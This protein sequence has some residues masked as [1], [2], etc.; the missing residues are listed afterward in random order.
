[1]DPLNLQ[2]CQFHGGAIDY[3]ILG[4]TI[5]NCLFERV[6]TTLYI[7]AYTSDYLEPLYLRNNLFWNGSLQFYFGTT[8]HIIQDNVFYQTA[9]AD[10]TSV[11]YTAEYNAYY[12]PTNQYMGITYNPIPYPNVTNNTDVFLTNDPG[13]QVG[14]LGNY[15]LP[16][17]ASNLIHTGNTNADLLGLYHY[18]ITTN[19]IKETTRIVSI[20]YHYVAVDAYGNPVD[21]NGDGIPDYLEDGNGN[22]SVDPGEVAWRNP[23]P[24]PP[25]SAVKLAHWSFNDP[26]NFLDDQGCKRRSKSA[27]GS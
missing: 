13:Y 5:T 11:P 15:Y 12:A 1:M 9:I 24:K 21:T 7:D 27:E 4:A 23:P 3:E 8:N 26:P 25:N 10:Y 6:N 19:Q 16:I 2:D 18:T 22:G 17:N 14:A 20:G